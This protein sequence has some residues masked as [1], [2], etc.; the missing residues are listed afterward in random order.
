MMRRDTGWVRGREPR[1]SAMGLWLVL[2]DVRLRT[3]WLDQAAFVGGH[4]QLRPVAASRFFS[5]AAT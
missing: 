4:Y 3:S 5:S 2:P 1:S